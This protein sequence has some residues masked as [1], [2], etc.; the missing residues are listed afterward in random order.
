MRAAA[1]LAMRERTLGVDH[2]DLKELRTTIAALRETPA[3]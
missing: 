1:T 2:A 3:K